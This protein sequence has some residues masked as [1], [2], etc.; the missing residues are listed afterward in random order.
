VV[1]ES[2]NLVLA[3]R[4][5]VGDEHDSSCCTTRMILTTSVN[6]AVLSSRVSPGSGAS[7]T[8][9]EVR[10]LL[11]SSKAFSAPS[12]QTQGSNFL[13]SL[14]NG[15]APSPILDMNQLRTTRQH[16]KLLDIFYVDWGCIFLIAL[17]FSWL[18]SIPHCE[19]M[20]PHFSRLSIMRVENNRSNTLAKSWRN[21]VRS[22][23]FTTMSST[24]TSIIPQI[25]SLTVFC[26]SL[27]KVDKAFFK[28]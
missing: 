7:M 11:R 23:D 15:S 24:Y 17:I 26:V 28:P 5:F 19:T 1:A 18:S 9:G 8:D 13:R 27:T 12:D 22:L 21:K 25:R 3:R 6:V 16:V 4:G 14:K 2:W 10:Y 20:K